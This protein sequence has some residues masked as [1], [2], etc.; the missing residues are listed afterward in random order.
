VKDNLKHY[1]ALV[2]G[3]FAHRAVGELSQETEAELAEVHDTLW[4]RMTGAERDAAELL[5]EEV[6]ER[7]ASQ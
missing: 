2:E 6:K 1:M 7:W 3:L 4:R 5:I